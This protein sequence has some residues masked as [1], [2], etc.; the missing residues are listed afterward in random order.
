MALLDWPLLVI[1]I[2]AVMRVTRLVTADYITEPIRGRLTKRWGEDA[3]RSYLLTC[4]YCASIY[5]GPPIVAVAA[6]WPDNRAV[7][8]GLVALTASF[9]AGIVASHE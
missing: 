8:I 6:L 5:V 1:T 4:D 7:I 3:K 2:G 9:I